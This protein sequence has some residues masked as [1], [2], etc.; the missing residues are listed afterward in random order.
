VCV[1]SEDATGRGGR[2]WQRLREELTAWLRSRFRRDID[3]ANLAGD[4]VLLGMGTFGRE[5]TG[6]VGAIWRWLRRTALNRVYH[7]HRRAMRCR[8]LLSSELDAVP[9][10]SAVESTMAGQV[11]E[12]MLTMS[13]GVERQVL[14]MLR[15]GGATNEAMAAAIGVDKRTIERARASLRSRFAALLQNIRQGVGL[16]HL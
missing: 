1:S 10:A 12:Q 3:A 6:P 13:Q 11:V 9:V 14:Q 4:T 16:E 7:D 2:I 8:I 15:A 5:P